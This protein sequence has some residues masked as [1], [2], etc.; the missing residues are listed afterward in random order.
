MTPSI[1]LLLTSFLSAS[2][3]VDICFFETSND[4]D[5]S[6]AHLCCNNFPADRCCFDNSNGFCVDT[7]VFGLE[8][9]SEQADEGAT[10][11]FFEDGDCTAQ[12]NRGGT[13]NDD[14]CCAF[15]G[16]QEDDSCSGE[17][18]FDSQRRKGRKRSAGIPGENCEDP[19][20]AHYVQ[21]NGT[22]RDIHVPKGS[23][24]TVVQMIHA[25]DREGL[26][27]F[28]DWNDQRDFD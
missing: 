8:E 17:W 5:T 2:L 16:L 13:C 26:A 28:E 12:Q 7:G 1:L 10:Y 11:T 18:A 23:L 9:E 25:K 6:K 22:G 14:D 27:V 3:A 15:L 24:A 21:A 19:N 4:C 20:F